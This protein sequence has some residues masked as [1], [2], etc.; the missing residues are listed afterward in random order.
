MVIEP[1]KS[2]LTACEQKNQVALYRMLPILGILLSKEERALR[3][4]KLLKI[5]MRKWLNAADC[6]LKMMI[7]P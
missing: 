3:G 5:V 1:I 4:K 6:L 2:L 7:L